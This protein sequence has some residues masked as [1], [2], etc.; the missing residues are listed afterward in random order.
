MRFS[1]SMCVALLA[2]ALVVPNLHAQSDQLKENQMAVV[3]FDIRL[4]KLRD[5]EMAKTLGVEDRVKGMVPPGSDIDPS[6]VKRV[7][8][9]MS[10]PESVAAAGAY[11]GDGPLPMEVFV[12]IEFVDS[13]AADKMFE[14][15]NADSKSEEIGGKTYM[16]PTDGG[17]PENLLAHRVNETT[18]EFG[19]EA[20]L[21]RADRKVFTDGLTA[22]FGKAPNEAIRIAMDLEGA[23][24]LVEELQGMAAESGPPNFAAYYELIGAISDMHISIDADGP[25]LLTLG[26]TGKSESEAEDLEGGLGSLVGMGQMFGMGAIGSFKEQ[27]PELGGMAEEILTKLKAEREGDQVVIKLIHPEGFAEAVQGMVGEGMGGGG[28]GD[29]GMGSGGMGSDMKEV[30]PMQKTPMP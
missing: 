13:A 3:S 1:M 6:E 23:G 15:I 20:Y 11:Q 19:T 30:V 21:L 17:A 27:S 5:S 25:N 22:A 29:D 12:R 2:V 7:F 24:P 9:A 26:M 14:Q 10:A 28:M 4:D 16:R 18:M 8:G